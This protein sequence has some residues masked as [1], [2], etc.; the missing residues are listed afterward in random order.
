MTSQHP[1]GESQGGRKMGSDLWKLCFQF[2]RWPLWGKTRGVY[3][4]PTSTAALGAV[5]PWT[6]SGWSPKSQGLLRLHVRKGKMHRIQEEQSRQVLLVSWKMLELWGLVLMIKNKT[7]TKQNQ[8]PPQKAN[9]TKNGTAAIFSSLF[10]FAL[11]GRRTWEV[12]VLII[13]CFSVFHLWQIYPGGNGL[14]MT[15]PNWK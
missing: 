12:A 15:L 1:S 10:F 14:W 7:E 8:S 2:C 5:F 6:C 13:L 4:L 3:L 9:Q 11:T